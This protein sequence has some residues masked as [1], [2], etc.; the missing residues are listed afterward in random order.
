MNKLLLVEDSQTI[1]R[2]LA[3]A[4]RQHLNLEVDTVY[5]LAEC[6]TKHHDDYFVA[7]VDLTLPDAPNGEAAS[8][9]LARNVPVIILTAN[10]NEDSR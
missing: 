2:M 6:L 9:L 8:A 5:T 3:Q 4:I 7:L 1:S 10:L